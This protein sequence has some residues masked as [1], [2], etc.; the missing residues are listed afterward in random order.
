M[1]KKTSR[2]SFVL[3][4]VGLIA[5]VAILVAVQKSATANSRS[6]LSAA[7]IIDDE[8]VRKYKGMAAL[9]S[10]E[11]KNIFRESSANDKSA[12]WQ[13]HFSEYKKAHPDLSPEQI[14]VL[15]EAANLA[16]P[17]TFSLPGNQQIKN[18][19]IGKALQNLRNH[20]VATFSQD[21]ARKLFAQLG[22][23]E[24]SIVVRRDCNCSTIDTWCGGNYCRDHAYN[25]CS[26]SDWGCGTLWMASCNGGC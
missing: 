21:E 23:A 16:I 1:S 12:L 10:E 5:V 20:A 14:K 25:G 6:S 22:N 9:S 2:V 8:A 24:A 11:R 3:L 18:A 13:V 4:A 19:V 26:T 7:I 15:E 17:L